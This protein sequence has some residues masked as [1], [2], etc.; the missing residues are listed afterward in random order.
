MRIVRPLP[1]QVVQRRGC[2]LLAGRAGSGRVVFELADGGTADAAGARAEVAVE[3]LG[4]AAG[5]VAAVA[6]VPARPGAPGRWEVAVEVPAGGWY[7]AT[8]TLRH[9][10]GVV[11][12]ESAPFGVGEVYLVGGQSHAGNSNDALFTVDDPEGRVV[13]LDLAAGSWRVAHDPQPVA[14]EGG[15]AGAAFWSE[16]GR[17]LGRH[18]KM[19]PCGGSI[20]LP[21]M[22]RLL[23]CLDVPIGMVNVSRAGY[24][25][26]QWEPG[27][28]AFA[29]LAAGLGAAGPVRAVLWQQ[30]ESDVIEGVCTDDYAA[31]HRRLRR[32]LA[33]AAGFAPVWLLA[34]STHHPTVYRLPAAEA[35]IRRAVDLM[36][37]DDADVAAGPDTDLLRGRNRAPATASAHL[38][39]LGQDNAGALWFAALLG[40]IA[41]GP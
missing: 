16:M 41:A 22:N 30:G 25:L 38:S 11:G 21:A 33:E 4:A 37:R 29:E 20:W 24:A 14:E 2:D 31:R 23:S 32:A 15:A 39:R 26:R 18:G 3:R 35:E 1:F 34:R 40:Q 8:V 17:R 28:E 7:R 36:I 13:A 9:S 10:G 19:L 12:A 6:D 5:P 27:G